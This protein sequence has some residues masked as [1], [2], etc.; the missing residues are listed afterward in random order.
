LTVLFMV[1]LIVCSYEEKYSSEW[2]APL[3]CL[4]TPLQ[5]ESWEN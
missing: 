3:S 4:C 1:P 5:W 2:Q